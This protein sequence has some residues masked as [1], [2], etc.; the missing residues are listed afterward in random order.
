V[1]QCFLFAPN[2]GQNR[3]LSARSHPDSLNLDNDFH[4]EP[5]IINIVGSALA[6]AKELSEIKLYWHEANI[7]HHHDGVGVT[8]EQMENF[9]PFFRN[10]NSA[11]AR[12]INKAHQRTGAVFAGPYRVAPCLDDESAETCLRY[13]LINVLKDHQVESLEENPFFSTYR[14]LAFGEAQKFWSIDWDEFYRKGGFKVKG[15][16]PKNFL[17][18][19]ELKLDPLPGWENLEIKKRQRRVQQI[20]K[21]AEQELK[22]LRKEEGRTVIGVAALKETDPRSR[23]RNPKLSKKKP[24]CHTVDPLLFIYYCESIREIEN[25]FIKASW[26]YRNGDHEREFPVGTF[27]PPRCTLTAYDSS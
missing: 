16:R 24:I 12:G 17:D 20:A 22:D 15:N 23:P 7:N 25:E 1:D 18:W 4:P 19:R 2:H 26:D 13:A 6:R 10:A 21:D 3:L 5:S 11:I 14:Q 8:P 9:A 27:R